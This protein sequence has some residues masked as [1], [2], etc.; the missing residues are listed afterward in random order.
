M[1][2]AVKDLQITIDKRFDEMK[3]ENQFVVKQLQEQVDKV[4]DEF[5]S[6]MEGLTKRWSQR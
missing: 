6:R 5:N 1:L 3:Y 4:R 2:K